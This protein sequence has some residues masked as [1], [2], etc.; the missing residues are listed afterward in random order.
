M[1]NLQINGSIAALR[2]TLRALPGLGADGW[3]YAVAKASAQP[4]HQHLQGLYKVV[5]TVPGGRAQV[6]VPVRALV[7]AL[8]EAG[9]GSRVA[10]PDSEVVVTGADGAPQVGGA[11]AR[12]VLQLLETRLSAH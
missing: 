9:R 7:A 2:L 12:Q 1:I 4:P 5:A 11:E 3:R 6:H 8:A 10:L